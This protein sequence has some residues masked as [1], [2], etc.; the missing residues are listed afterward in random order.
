MPAY[1]GTG[2]GACALLEHGGLKVVAIEHAV[3]WLAQHHGNLGRKVAEVSVH[4]KKRVNKGEMKV[5]IRCPILAMATLVNGA[6]TIEWIAFVMSPILLRNKNLNYLISS[7]FFNDSFI[8]IHS[9][10]LSYSFIHS[11][12]FFHNQS[13]I[14]SFAHSVFL[15]LLLL[16]SRH[17]HAIR[18]G[19]S[20]VRAT[21][22]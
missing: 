17:L 9:I 3:A 19:S 16:S 10:I 21:V 4:E 7:S 12:S 20:A 14:H 5:R 18:T 15:L 8:H 13:F 1:L 11:Y 6:R 22:G 2:E